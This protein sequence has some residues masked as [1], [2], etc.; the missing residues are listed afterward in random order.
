MPTLLLSLELVAL[1]SLKKKKKTLYYVQTKA[2]AYSLYV[3]LKN[4]FTVYETF[5]WIHCTNYLINHCY[6]PRSLDF[7]VALLQNLTKDFGQNNM[8]KAVEESYNITLKPW[9]GWISSAAFKVIKTIPFLLFLCILTF[10]RLINAFAS[11]FQNLTIL[12]VCIQKRYIIFHLYSNFPFFF[13]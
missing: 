10:K 8:E 11:D 12:K 4:I 9:H 3:S 5:W 7:T 2:R 6:S 13:F 1:H